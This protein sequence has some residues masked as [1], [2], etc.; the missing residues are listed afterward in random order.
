MTGLLKRNSAAVPPLFYLGTLISSVGSSTF[1]ICLIAFMHA[2]GYSLFASSLIIGLCRLIP[3]L[4][5]TLLGQKA[6]TLPPKLTVVLTEIGAALGS[7][8][9]L[10]AWT[11]GKSGYTW[12]AAFS[13]ARAM[14]LS[15]QFGGRARIVK[16]LAEANYKSQSRHTVWLNQVTQGAMVFA[17]MAAWIAIQHFHFEHVILFDG[18][19]F[20]LNGLILLALPIGGASSAQGTTASITKKF[21]D[22]YY[23]NPKA[24]VLDLILALMMMGTVSFTS[25]LAG[26]DQQ[27]LSIFMISYGCSVWASGYIE[28][29]AWMKDRAAFVWATLGASYILLGTFPAMGLATWTLCFAKDI[30]YWILFHRISS[31]IQHDTPSNVIGSVTNARIAQMVIVL[32]LGEMAVGGGQSVCPIALDGAW[33]GIVGLGLAGILIFRRYGEQQQEYGYDRPT[34]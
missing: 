20:L 25:R 32:A 21:R 10:W 8:G 16:Q 22:L 26:N 24:A 6:D 3:I 18:L 27:W 2:A 31:Y 33:R 11:E 29:M 34:L 28:R 13:V 1:T 15:L 14:L 9:I 19:T 7:I 5:T 4:S 12:L 30:C 23:W 17:G